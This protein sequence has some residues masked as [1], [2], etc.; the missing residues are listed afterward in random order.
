M[1]RCVW[2]RRVCGRPH[3]TKWEA[4][5]FYPRWFEKEMKINVIFRNWKGNQYR[6]WSEL[7]K[8]SPIMAGSQ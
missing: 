2:W 5:T 8:S 6:G 3:S 1:G 4:K 7:A